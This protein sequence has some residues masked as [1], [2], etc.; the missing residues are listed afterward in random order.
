MLSLMKFF[1]I[2]LMRW[3]S[4]LN[5]MTKLKLSLVSLLFTL[6]LY[7]HVS[8]CLLYYVASWDR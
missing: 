8:G 7:V 6:L 2:D 1:N 5:E 4:N 3:I